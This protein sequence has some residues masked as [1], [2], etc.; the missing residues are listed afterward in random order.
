MTDPTSAFSASMSSPF[1]PREPRG[2][3]YSLPT[4]GETQCSSHGTCVGPPG[5]GAILVCDCD[6]GY[7]GLSCE[8][9]VNG[10]LS[11][12][13]TL[14]VLA[15]IFGLLIVAFIIAKVRQMQKKRNRKLLAEKQGYNIVV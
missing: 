15:F 3:D 6:L 7:R 9:T 12:P 11:L 13:L 2:I 1:P 5:G 10:A 14:S 8:D 4:C